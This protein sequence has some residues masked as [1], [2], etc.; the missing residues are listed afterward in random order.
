MTITASPA[1]AAIDAHRKVFANTHL[2]DLFASDPKRVESL[3]LSFDDILYDFSKQ[4]LTAETLRLLAALATEA[5]VSDWT[6]RMFAGERINISEG[7]S[8]LH[9]ALRLSLIHI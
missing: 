5:K 1:W 3:T 7:R 2:R 9:A 4:R 6:E 8:V